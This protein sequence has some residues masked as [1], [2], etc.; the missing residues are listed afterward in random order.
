MVN[1]IHKTIAIAV[2][3]FLV[4]AEFQ[5][6]NKG[7]FVLKFWLSCF[8][9]T[10][11]Q[12]VVFFSGLTKKAFPFFYLEFYLLTIQ[13]THL[14]PEYDLT[15]EFLP[16]ILNIKSSAKNVPNIKY[17]AKLYIFSIS[18]RTQEYTYLREVR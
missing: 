13:C 14:N 1:W 7:I 12:P 2:F 5:L 4:C 11:S 16:N 10:A 17:W 3:V 9:G 6:R 15:S 8:R 18:L